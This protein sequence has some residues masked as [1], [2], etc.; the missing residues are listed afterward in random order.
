MSAPLDL[1]STAIVLVH[2]AWHGAWC[3][4]RLLPGLWQA[5]HRA[6]AVTLTGTRPEID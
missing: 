3:W 2:G 5:G 1:S 6:F 4:K